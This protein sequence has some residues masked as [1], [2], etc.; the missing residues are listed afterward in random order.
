MSLSPKGGDRPKG[1]AQFLVEEPD[2]GRGN[3][4]EE[5]LGQL[6]KATIIRDM[7]TTEGW[8]TRP[9]IAQELG[10][11]VKTVGRYINALREMGYD[12]ESARGKG[13]RLGSDFCEGQLLLNEEELYALFLSLAKSASSF[14]KA[15]V[16]NL[17]RRL[18]NHLSATNR[19]K[20][21]ALHDGLTPTNGKP[22]QDFGVLADI[23]SALA[24]EWTLRL[25]YQGLKDQHPSSRSVAPLNITNSREVWYLEA[26]DLD[27][28]GPRNFRL[29]RI[30]G[31]TLVRVKFRRT[32]NSAD[33]VHH[34]WDF[35]EGQDTVKLRLTPKLAKWLDENPAHPSQKLEQLQDG[36]TRCTFAVK[37]RE[38][39]LDWLIGLRG[40]ELLEPEDF[41]AALRDRAMSI[42]S[43]TGTFDIG[44]E[45]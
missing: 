26:W 20:A 30:S 12:I 16:E 2:R 32:E 18:I 14:S 5:I 35:G 25:T 7:L 3:V 42:V 39:F 38:K 34:P 10:V 23:F 22:P 45:I 33:F 6:E 15:V 19:K 24:G 28:E 40:F 31:S 21:R 8:T 27:K 13:V 36:S 17:R 37:S 9:A 44:W 29:D 11:D 1:F 4:G 41:R 43:R